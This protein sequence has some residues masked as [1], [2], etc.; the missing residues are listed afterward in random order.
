MKLIRNFIAGLRALF[1]KRKA[2]AEL[3][4]ELRA[5]VEAS[6]AEKMKSGMARDA[7]LRAARLEI[8]SSDAV[9]EEVHSVGWETA[10]DSFF[11]DIRFAFRMLRKSPGFACIAIL[12]LALGIGANTAIFSVV[13]TVLLRPLPYKDAS[14]L[15][16]VWGANRARGYDLDLVS[17]PDY[18]DWKSQNCVFETMG[19]STD[20]M[21]TLT[22][23]GEP[24]AVIGYQ[25]SPDYFDALGVPAL[26]GRTFAPDESQP[27]KDRV[28]VLSH[29]LWVNRFGRDPHILGRSIT[30]DGQAY[31]V[32]GVMPPAFR[33]PPNTELWTPLAIDPNYANDRSIRWVRVAARLKQDVTFEQA[34]TE[35]NT[36]AARLRNEYPKTNKDYYV[37]LVTL[38]ELTTGDVRP[39]LL[40]LLGSVG[41]VLLIACANVANLLLS[42]AVARQ[43]EIAV[44]T[45]LGATRFRMIRQFLT[46]SVLLALLGGLLG[47]LVAYWGAS[48]LVAMFPTSVAN[49]SIPLVE[50]IPIDRWVLGFAFLASLAT[51]I[52][53][54]LV[55]ALQACRS[56]AVEPLKESG[57]TNTGS[58]RQM[59]LRN[60]LIVSEVALSLVLL[61]AAALTI[62]SFFHLV[63]AN[64][65]FD[66]Q[67]LLSLR[68]LLPQ[69][70]YKTDAQKF[71]FYRDALARIQ[72]LPGV[73][74]A[75]TV[76]FLPL[77]G[78]WGT[79]EVSVASRPVDP[80]GKNPVTV[81][82]AVSPDYFRAMRIPLLAGRYFSGQDN[83]SGRD[84][85]ILSA[86]LARQLWPNDDAVGKEVS[87]QGFDKPRQVVGVVGDVYQLGI[88][89]HQAGV[90]RSTT[91][92]V[93]LP[94]DQVPSHLLCF[95]IRAAGDPLTIAKAVQSA[96][97]K[98]D[99]EQAI[100]F[101][102]TMDQLASETVLLQ[103]ASM[104]LFAVFA[105]LALVLASIG[106]YGV[107]SY[108][109]S[110]RTHE[111]GIRVALGAGSRVVLR[112]IMGEGLILTLVGAS[113]GLLGAFG[114]MRF[115][116]SMLYGVRSSDPATFAV[117][118]LV[119]IG[120]ALF[121][122]YIPARRAMRVDPM[123][124]LRHE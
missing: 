82:S 123:V 98:V 121:A 46:E 8:G 124:A 13:N 64:L 49:L 72:S 18:L 104:I 65:G 73:Q 17:Y 68:V 83:A 100:S 120:V 90:T 111:I 29:R 54:G 51:G 45:A 75:G 15:V 103:R 2:N 34:R 19:A 76:T 12:T 96:I 55:P 102:E 99:N 7:A 5:Y 80:A 4:E 107:I 116:S 71:A 42:R 66:P 24:A 86:G 81:W 60:V 3:D 48:A 101:V 114:L 58:A 35:M 115:L 39:A 95:V 118:P 94:N 108:S 30:L 47:M 53:F 109:A 10:V 37:N 38:R 56:N 70:K 28:T 59:S 33:Y 23:A 52:L 89:V 36:I 105:G 61:T 43:R 78:W 119:L 85:V 88:G 20:E 63:R 77:S 25:F 92:E 14:R 69:Y 31:V 50:S 106:I 113:I 87:V 97:W 117:V 74:A 84:A 22:G 27:G 112:L 9:K 79:R 41:L 11:Q 67:H 26:L 93:Y 32:V 21:F 91:F 44:R 62:Q 6:A 16:T 122:C 57:R 40:I 1:G 110:R